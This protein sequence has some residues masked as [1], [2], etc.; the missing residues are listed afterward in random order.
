MECEGTAVDDERGNMLAT[1]GEPWGMLNGRWPG[2][3]KRDIEFADGLY[4]DVCVWLEG[5]GGSQR[6][7]ETEPPW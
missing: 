5:R 6:S 4:E 1:D 7:P 2:V 3:V